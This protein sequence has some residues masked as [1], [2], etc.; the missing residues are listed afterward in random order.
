M[1]NKYEYKYPHA[2]I[3]IIFS[4]NKE[5]FVGLTKVDI[6]KAMGHNYRDYNKI[7]NSIGR[8]H[9]TMK[10]KKYNILDDPEHIYFEVINIPTN[11]SKELKYA[12]RILKKYFDQKHV[13]EELYKNNYDD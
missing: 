8:S 10:E 6:Y 3:Y 1:L 5:V 4:K 12:R 13:K 2:N 7:K 9:T 11:D